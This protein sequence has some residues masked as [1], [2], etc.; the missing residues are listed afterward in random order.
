VLSFHVSRYLFLMFIFLFIVRMRVL[1]TAYRFIFLQ[2]RV[3]IVFTRFFL[4]LIGF[5]CTTHD[6]YVGTI[7]VSF[8]LFFV[9][10]ASTTKESYSLLNAKL[11]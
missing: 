4:R 5:L 6:H 3:F 7:T 11:I 10:V 8:V 1:Y 9:F 2:L